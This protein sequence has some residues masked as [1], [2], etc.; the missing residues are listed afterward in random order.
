MIKN[1]QY[2]A[3]AWHTAFGIHS[4][5]FAA[6]A[7]PFFSGSG[8]Q[9]NLDALR[10]LAHFSN[11][12]LLVTGDKG[13]GKSLL[14]EKL[15]DL[16][17]S[18]LKIIK[19][20]PK[21]LQG[22][23]SLVEQLADMNGLTIG[24]DDSVED[25]LAKISGVCASRF[26]NGYRTL[27]VF[28]DAHELSDD[29]LELLVSLAAQDLAE[30]VF[31]ILLFAQPQI[32]EQIR[33]LLS[34]N[35]Q[36]PFHQIQLKNLNKAETLAYVEAYL[37]HAGWRKKNHLPQKLS[38]KL[39]EIGRGNP[40]R[41]NRLAATVLLA[42]APRKLP[43]SV[44][45]PMIFGV[46][47]AIAIF[48]SIILVSVSYH[49]TSISQVE[50]ESARVE[51]PVAIDLSSEG[52]A[53]ESELM[54]Q[55]TENPSNF[56]PE[57]DDRNLFVDAELDE[58]LGEDAVTRNDQIKVSSASID[59][60]NEDTPSNVNENQFEQGLTETTT[61][62]AQPVQNE[63]VTSSGSV[64]DTAAGEQMGREESIAMDTNATDDRNE[65]SRKNQVTDSAVVSQLDDRSGSESAQ[66]SSLKRSTSW[67]AGQPVDSWTIQILGSYSEATATK[68]LDSLVTKDGFY[69]VKS[70]YRGKQWFV[71]LNGVYP[72]K[73]AARSG[74]KKLPKK[75][76]DAGAWIR[77][78][79][80]LTII[81]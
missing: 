43:F 32:I 81:D 7:K 73:E 76:R 62:N 31:G 45:L 34:A 2:N 44:S 72:T 78:L 27:F 79:S 37:A 57:Y 22:S 48:A 64:N 50:I 65:V 61:E 29:S 71:V 56:G 4:D 68:L 55:T 30:S 15:C 69:Y 41:I 9:E 35:A 70:T 1:N 60:G 24:E 12:I 36:Q 52:K 11:R 25:L 47:A 40:G 74:L 38:E 18:A 49:S 80:G 77:S 53:R 58:I 10:H 13:S 6:K 51:I 5:P 33:K 67:L 66:V 54:G 21:L 39:Y 46:G 28:D 19:V 3:E 14:L 16:E 75:L 8:R 17:S 23:A 42:E 20:K 59:S 26:K 63:P